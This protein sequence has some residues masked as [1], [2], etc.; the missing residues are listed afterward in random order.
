VEQG[1]HQ[2]D[3][4]E[5]IG[6]CSYCE[7]VEKIEPEHV[8]PRAIFLN[9]NQS[10]I[11]IPACHR[12]NNDK[13][14]GEDDLRDSLVIEVGVHGHPDILPLMS[15]MAQ[16][17]NKGFSKY[18]QAATES[19]PVIRTTS[20]GVDIP[21]YEVHVH[22]ARAMRRTLR[23]IVRGLYFHENG[24]PWLPDQP[25]TLYDLPAHELDFTIET[26][27]RLGSFQFRGHMGNDVFKYAAITQ[28][29]H[30]DITGWL[31]VFFGTVP[32]LAVTGIPENEKE[33][34]EPKFADLIRG[35]GRRERKLKAIVDRGLVLAPPEDL[36]DFL[37]MHEERRKRASF[38]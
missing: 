30:P 37:N 21:A 12:C 31:M 24:R 2:E 26:F 36:L 4:E 16:S 11:I 38:N 6:T 22:D 28:E 20:A 5:K 23:Y 8:V 3:S 15:V 7:A 1:N 33:R 10:T 17:A 29:E 25:M 35:K 34:Y 14:G 27:G 13:S 32:V 18:G 19:K 9:G